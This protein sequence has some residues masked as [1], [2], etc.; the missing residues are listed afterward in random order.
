MAFGEHFGMK[1]EYRR[2]ARCGGGLGSR[3]KVVLWER[4]REDQITWKHAWF[5]SSSDMDNNK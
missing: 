3:F 5:G 2:V 4:E 1:I